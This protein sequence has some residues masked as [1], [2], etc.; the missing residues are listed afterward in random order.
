MNASSFLARG[1]AGLLTAC[2][3]AFGAPAAAQDTPWRVLVGFPPGG[4]VDTV[5]RVLA[6]KLGPELNRTV[7]VE[8]RPGAGG[9]VLAA[10][11]KTM[12]SDG[13]VVK[14]APDALLT[15]TSSSTARR[16]RIYTGSHG[17]CAS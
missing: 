10:A 11:L 9:R 8:S 5:A 15:T 6:E 4:S 17:R 14:L 3:C 16:S 2:L 13:S 7:I 12:P 1:A